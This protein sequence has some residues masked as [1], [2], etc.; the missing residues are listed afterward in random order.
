MRGRSRALLLA[1]LVAACVS[2][3]VPK[4][5]GYAPKWRVGDWWLTKTF[6]DSPT[7]WG[8]TW[9]YRRY[10]VVRMAKVGGHSSFLLIT[11]TADRYGNGGNDTVFSFVRADNWLVVREE[12]SLGRRPRAVRNA[13][14]GRFGGDGMGS[15]RIPEFP[16]RHGDP[17]TSF[18]LL[19]CD[20]GYFA[21]LREISSPADSALVKRLLDDGDTVSVTGLFAKMKADSEKVRVLRPTGAVYQVREEIGGDLGTD[22][23][24]ISQ[25][26]QFWSND[27]PWRVYEERALLDGLNP[28]RRVYSRTW[29]IA[30]GHKAK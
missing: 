15:Q 26:L 18:K 29:L 22:N 28:V 21:E 3:S 24:R 23:S 16:L 12:V 17:D 9:H 7:G 4:T 2:T 6:E 5:S 25:S 14:H 19:K 8:R 13:P 1:L 10:D 20:D 30:S 27:Q 11:R